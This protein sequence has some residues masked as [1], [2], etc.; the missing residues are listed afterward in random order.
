M[1]R[2][3]SAGN[4]SLCIEHA[5]DGIAKYKIELISEADLVSVQTTGFLGLSGKLLSAGGQVFYALATD[6]DAN[7]VQQFIKDTQQ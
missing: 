7:A 2:V 1:I 3:K 4:T 6:S 5:Q